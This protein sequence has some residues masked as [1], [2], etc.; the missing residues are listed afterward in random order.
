MSTSNKLAA[1][2]KFRSVG[3]NALR[4]AMIKVLVVY[5]VQVK[6]PEV[7]QVPLVV[8]YGDDSISLSFVRI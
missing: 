2:I 3:T 7:S 1:L 5:D 8:N 4:P 6:A